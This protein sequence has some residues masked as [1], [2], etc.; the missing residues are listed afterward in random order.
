MV[1][2]AHDFHYESRR[3]L[4]WMSCVDLDLCYTLNLVFYFRIIVI[5]MVRVIVT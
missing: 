2:N 1:I 5:V 3:L 4:L